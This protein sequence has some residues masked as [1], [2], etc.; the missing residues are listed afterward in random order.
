M[1]G[2]LSSLGWVWWIEWKGGRCGPIIKVLEGHA[3]KFTFSSGGKWE[4]SLVF[5]K[6][7]IM[8]T[9]ANSYKICH[10]FLI[11]MVMFWDS[12]VF[13]ITSAHLVSYNPNN[14]HSANT[15]EHFHQII[16]HYPIL[17]KKRLDFGTFTLVG[18]TTQPVRGAGIRIQVCLTV[19]FRRIPGHHVISFH[20]HIVNEVLWNSCFYL[21]LS[22]AKER[23]NLWNKDILAL[24]LLL[25]KERFFFPST[26]SVTPS[27]GDWAVR[28][29]VFVQ[30]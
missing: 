17:H 14:V 24:P 12:Q 20:Q 16:Y 15:T 25:R 1:W 3:K 29:L 2:I 6:R 30:F 11:I 5:F 22:S 26:L 23:W 9:I 18:R 28:H 4:P 19:K 8:I 13:P 10:I 21:G 27:E 7:W